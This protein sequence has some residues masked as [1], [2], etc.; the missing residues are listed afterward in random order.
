[1]ALLPTARPGYRRALPALRESREA[2][3]LS[4]LELA[5]RLG[6]PANTLGRIERGDV[7]ASSEWQA[8]LA[9]ELQRP[10]GELF[11]PAA[12]SLRE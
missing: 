11:A 7:R 9:E 2:R 8:A 6:F 5:R 4:S 10:I 1:M 3:G 12:S